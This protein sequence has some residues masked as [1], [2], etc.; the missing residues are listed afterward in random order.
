MKRCAALTL[1]CLILTGATRAED[2]RPWPDLW[3]MTGP[4]IRAA[5]IDKSIAPDH[6]DPQYAFQYGEDFLRDGRWYSDRSMRGLITIA[7][8]WSIRDDQL[9]VA[10]DGARTGAPVGMTHCRNVWRTADPTRIETFDIG[11]DF[12]AGR[13]IV[14]VVKP[15]MR[16]RLL[17]LGRE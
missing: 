16:A 3:R 6:G 8:R 13:R 17:A 10:I 7:G 12:F 4:E 11:S 1:A 15:S 9:C 2:I 5:I 14:L